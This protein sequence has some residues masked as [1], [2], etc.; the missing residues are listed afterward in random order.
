[1]PATGVGGVHKATELSFGREGPTG[2]WAKGLKPGVAPVPREQMVGTAHPAMDV[3][4][5]S[6]FRENDPPQSL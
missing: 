2:G 3:R 1:M 4:L 5:D 6:R